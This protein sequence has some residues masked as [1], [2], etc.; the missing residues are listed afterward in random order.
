MT[1]CN[2][3]SFFLSSKLKSSMI[4]NCTA[5]TGQ[6]VKEKSTVDWHKFQLRKEI[7]EC[8]I[9]VATFLTA[10]SFLLKEF[11]RLQCARLSKK[12]FVIRHHAIPLLETQFLEMQIAKIPPRKWAHS[13]SYLQWNFSPFV[14]YMFLC[15][16]TIPQELKYNRNLQR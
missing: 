1:F 7:F 11:N 13:W 16:P 8:L 9:S 12:E 14:T 5:T 15:I 4:L 3:F 2:F 6:L 10:A